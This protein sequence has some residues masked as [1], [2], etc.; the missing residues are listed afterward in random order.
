MVAESTEILA[1]MLQFGCASAWAGV[2]RAI[3]SR[4]QAR[5]GPPE[6]VRIRRATCWALAG[7]NTWKIAECSE[8]TGITTPPAS[9]AVLSRVG[10]AQIRLSLLASATTAPERAAARVGASPANP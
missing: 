4:L 10:P 1:P 2:A 6:A 3:C 8:S 9:L 7:E 5:N